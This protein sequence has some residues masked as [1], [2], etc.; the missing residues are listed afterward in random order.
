[1]GKE[2]P[3]MQEGHVKRAGEI[4][5]QLGHS[6][7]KA[8]ALCVTSRRESV[9]GKMQVLAASRARACAAENP[10]RRPH[11]RGCPAGLLDPRGLLVTHGRNKKAG[12]GQRLKRNVHEFVMHE[13][14]AR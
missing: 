11:E 6:W 14:T 1:M 8:W 12:R 2:E 7:H 3:S 5:H 9:K 4:G 13:L 10:C